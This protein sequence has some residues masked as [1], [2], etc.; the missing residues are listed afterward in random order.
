MPQ[1]KRHVSAAA[2]QAAYRDRCEQARRMEQAA[3]GLPSLPVIAS[4]PGW[5]RWNASLKA[6]HEMIACT[7]EEMNGYFD[8]RSETWQQSDRGED[9]QA[10]I[11]AVEEVLDGLSSLIP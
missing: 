9:H 1:P 11:A 10:L 5:K 2:R 8:E 6:A 3:K 7:L 4:L